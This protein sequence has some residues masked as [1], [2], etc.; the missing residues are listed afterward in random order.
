MSGL[1]LEGNGQSLTNFEAGEIL[2]FEGDAPSKL[3]IISSGRVRLLKDVNG[4]QVSQIMKGPGDFVGEVSIF[5]DEPQQFTALIEEDSQ[6]AAVDSADI[7]KILSECP[8][9]ISNIMLTL[10]ERVT[11]L[12]ELMRDHRMDDPSLEGFSE[13]SSEKDRALFEQIKAHKES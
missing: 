13:L 1:K 11:A 9:W 10:G 6:I 5:L 4:R 7:K 3:F 2:F 12:R 8:E